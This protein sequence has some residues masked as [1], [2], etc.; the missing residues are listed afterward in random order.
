MQ[1]RIDW[2]KTVPEAY[3]AVA[4][5]DR[6]VRESGIETRYLHLIKIM[7]SHINGCA[8][9]IDM[10]V[11]HARKDGFSDQWISLVN[12]WRES[13]VYTDAER[14]VLAWTESLTLLADTRAADADFE[15][16]REYFDDEQI[17]NLT[18]AIGVINVWN[19]VTVGFRTQHGVDAP[20]AAA[21]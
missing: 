13:P 10:H 19:R 8:Y 7:A 20:E 11:K 16:L 17:T 15:P 4:A 3:R 14:A 12:V 9:C 18:V 21:A 1:A 2:A 6:Y 5:L